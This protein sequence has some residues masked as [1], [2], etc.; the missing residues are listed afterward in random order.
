MVLVR[1]QAL[2]QDR[3]VPGALSIT[4]RMRMQVLVITALQVV[5]HHHLNS[6]STVVHKTA[7]PDLVA[8][9]DDS[10]MVGTVTEDD[11]EMEGDRK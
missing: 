6:S 5:G 1:V 4:T 3:G 9:E 7:A 11:S 8:M 10:M 2:A